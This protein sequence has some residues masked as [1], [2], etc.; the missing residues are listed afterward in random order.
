[1]PRYEYKGEGERTF[2][3][4]GITVKKGDSFDGPDGLKAPGL[5]LASTAKT[6][7]AVPT[8]PKEEPKAETKTEESI[9][10]SAPSDTTAGV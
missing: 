3:S 2:P 6:A 4:L 7:P 10:P 5:S 1:M 9:K 8:A